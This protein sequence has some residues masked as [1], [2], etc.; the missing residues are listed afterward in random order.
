MIRALMRMVQGAKRSEI[1]EVSCRID[2]DLVMTGT[3]RLA[4]PKTVYAFPGQ[5]IQAKGM[6]LDARSRSKAA[7]AMMGILE[8]DTVRSPLA[9]I[10]ETNRKKLRQILE[11]CGL[12]IPN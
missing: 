1:V 9:P 6:G 5:G 3:G 10:T 7:M 4:A 11:E 2:G 8:N 12:E